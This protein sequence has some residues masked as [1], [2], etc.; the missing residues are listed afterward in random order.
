MRSSYC[1]YRVDSCIQRMFGRVWNWRE[2]YGSWK[3]NSLWSDYFRRAAS[4]VRWLDLQRKPNSQR[5]YRSLYVCGSVG[6]NAARRFPRRQHGNYFWN[7]DH[8]RQF[9][10]WCLS[11][12]FQ[13]S[14]QRSIV[15]SDGRERNDRK[16]SGANQS[17]ACHTAARAIYESTL[18]VVSD[19]VKTADLGGHV[20]TTE[21]TDQVIHRVRTK[22]DV[23]SSLADIEP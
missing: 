14:V 23:W 15:G 22:L 8:K 10:L 11:F 21:F 19:G 9:Q 2:K 20:G 17:T 4:S 7:P 3:S 12:R 13:G 18:E 1:D 5:R 6:P 16:H